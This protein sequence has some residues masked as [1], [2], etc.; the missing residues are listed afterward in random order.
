M[1]LTK[2]MAHQ[3]HVEHAH[4]KTFVAPPLLHPSINHVK[5][6]TLTHVWGKVTEV[7]WC[8]S[9]LPLYHLRCLPYG[10]NYITKTKYLRK[11][12]N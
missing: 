6:L 11:H 5:S 1:G 4:H 12:T 10:C 3:F 8:V 2:H 9:L 7:M